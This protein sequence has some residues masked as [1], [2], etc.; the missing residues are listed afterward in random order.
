MARFIYSNL[1]DNNIISVRAIRKGFWPALSM[2]AISKTSYNADYNN[3][4]DIE[5]LIK[6]YF[7]IMEI[8]FAHYRWGKDKN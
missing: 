3:F 8:F 5:S 2:L 7:P 1:V 4:N 6:G